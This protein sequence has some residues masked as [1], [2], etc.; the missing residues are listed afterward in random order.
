LLAV[1]RWYA[2]HGAPAPLRGLA[3]KKANSRKKS[4]PKKQKLAD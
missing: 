2:I 4:S 1:S 3:A